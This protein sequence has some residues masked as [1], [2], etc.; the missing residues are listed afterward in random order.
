MRFAPDGCPV[1][2]LTVFC[3]DHGVV[4]AHEPS[5]AGADKH[6]AELTVAPTLLRR[7]P[8]R[9]RVLTGAARFC[10]RHWCRQ[11]LKAQ[12]ADVLLVKGNPPR[13]HEAIRRLF[14]PPAATDPLPLPG[15][16]WVRRE[17]R[18]SENGHARQDDTRH[19]VASTELT[20]SLDWPGVAP[21][22]RLERTWREHGRTKREVRYGLTS[23]PPAVGT[24]PQV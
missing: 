13:R 19:L 22:F 20:G 8:W 5:A 24:P 17:T 9:G 16:R 21:V 6:E 4:L 10:Q 14:D 18:A 12:G 2:A 15:T 23:L 7:V 1:H 11:V 3:H